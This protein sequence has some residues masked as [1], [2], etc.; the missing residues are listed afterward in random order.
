MQK[1]SLKYPIRNSGLTFFKV[2]YFCSYIVYVTKQ[3]FLIRT[4]LISGPGSNKH[5]LN[6][7]DKVYCVK[8]PWFWFQLI[9]V[10]YTTT[11]FCNMD[12]TI[13]LPPWFVIRNSVMKSNSLKKILTFIEISENFI[14][15][16]MDVVM[17]V[18][19]M[20]HD[21]LQAYGAECYRGTFFPLQHMALPI[22]L[23]DKK[24]LA[25]G[26]RVISA[27]IKQCPIHN[28][29]SYKHRYFYDLCILN[30]PSITLVKY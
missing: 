29:L 13:Q 8:F 9:F 16:K 1:I 19:H 26:K 2:Q 6:N 20:Q 3:V 11:V 21:C 30:S 12:Q 28:T 14:Q 15:L 27:S 18:S 4:I 22:E 5:F 23:S 25:Q 7:S 17:C 24:Y 10:P